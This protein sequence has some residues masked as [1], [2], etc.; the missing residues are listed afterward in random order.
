[1][2]DPHGAAAPAVHR[3]EPGENSPA[4]SRR[5]LGAVSA[6]SRRG[7]PARGPLSP[8]AIGAMRELLAKTA[9][10][11]PRPAWHAEGGAPLCFW[12]GAETGYAAAQAASSANR[13]SCR[14]DETDRQCV[15]RLGRGYPAGLLDAAFQKVDDPF[16]RA[17][18]LLA[19]DGNSCAA[20]HTSFIQRV[21][22]HDLLACACTLLTNLPACV[23]LPIQIYLHVQIRPF[24]SISMS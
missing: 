10:T 17:P 16:G 15:V 12:R 7:Q 3:T 1:M 24:P 14:A 18:C 9:D 19:I 23:N 5:G 2:R 13:T 22:T 4:R 21:L 20:A 8:Q 6:R 11:R